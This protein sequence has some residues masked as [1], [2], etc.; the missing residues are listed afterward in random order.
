MNLLTMSQIKHVSLIFALPLLLCATLG[1]CKDKHEDRL[2]SA[3]DDEEVY[4]DK[5]GR[6][7]SID[8][9]V[10][11]YFT[12]P[13]LGIKIL[14]VDK[15][16]LEYSIGAPPIFRNIYGTDPELPPTSWV[17]SSS[18][19][20][21]V[22]DK[23]WTT[24]KQFKIWWERI[25]DLKLYIKSPKYDYYTE[26]QTRAGTAWCEATITISKAPPKETGYFIL[27][28]YPD[29][30]VDARI[31]EFK[32]LTAEEPMVKDEDRTKLPVLTDKP[33][34]KEIPNPY[35]GLTKPIQM[36]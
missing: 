27:D 22:W 2:L 25:V 10:Y 8:F 16:G 7:Q 18:G 28:F 15:N 13:I 17:G 23:K 24:P 33:C 21:I 11:S 3:I 34:L 14:P 19:N 4:N 32:D 6:Y 20:E 35:Y 31:S 36:N 12:Y 5:T 29:G 9:L 26:K 1:A 30:Q